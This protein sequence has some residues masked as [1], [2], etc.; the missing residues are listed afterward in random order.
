MNEE[1][2]PTPKKDRS[3]PHWKA[4]NEIIDPEVNIGI[5]D[6]G[7]IYQI[8]FDKE[9]NASV[10]MT[11]TSPACPVGPVLVQQVEDKLRMF[12]ELNDISVQ[13]VWEPMWNQSMI[14]E[15]IRELMFGI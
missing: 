14:D 10:I 15:D 5:I 4:L 6:L 1:I 12:P 3:T 9:N 11:L 7:L 8:N 13:I 2:T